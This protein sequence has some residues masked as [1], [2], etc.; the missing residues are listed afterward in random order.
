MKFDLVFKY[1]V[2]VLITLAFLFAIKVFNISYPL[3]ITVTNTTKSTELAIVGEGKVDVTP[4]TVYVDAG[5]T[6]NN[7]PTADEVQS[8]IDEVNN[9]LIDAMKALGIAKENIKT[10]SYNITPAY[11]Y[12]PEE[13][14]RITGYNGN[15]T[16]EIKIKDIKLAT[17][18][19]NEATGAGAN[20]V[21]GTRFTVDN[22]EKFREEAR[23]K[24]IQN[25]KD[26]AVKLAQNLGIS[27]GKVTNIVESN[28]SQPI[29]Y[30]YGLSSA[31][32]RAAGLGGGGPQ[33]EPGTQT[34]TS[35]VTLYFEKK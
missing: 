22:P 28:P 6:V 5:I 30:D 21:T 11:S 12:K 1:L 33:I 8:K 23:D 14:N 15:A 34:V 35:T 31:L 19:I 4:D 9:K 10:S 2:L 13:G 25:A 26:Q 18:V 20:E 32:P 7:L 3:D 27:L 24:A 16:V 17:K 29:N